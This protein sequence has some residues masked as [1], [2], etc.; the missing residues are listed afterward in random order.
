MI[1]ILPLLLLLCLPLAATGPAAAQSTASAVGGLGPRLDRAASDPAMRP[2]KTVI[3]ARDGRVLSERGFRGHSPSESTNI[4][5]A[6]KS[7]ISA[8]VGIAIDKGLLEGPDQKIAPILKA[9]LPVT[10]DPRINDIT[11]GNLL[12]MQAGLDRMSGANYGRW[13]SSRNW[14]R[15]ALSQPFVDQPGGEMLYSTASTHLLSAILTKVGR[16]PTLVL[17]REWLGPVEGFRIGA[18]ERDPQG[19]YLGGNQMAMSARSLLAFGELYRNGGKTAD[20]RQIVSADWISQSWQQRTNSR[21]SG[22]EYGYGWF[23]RQIGGEQVHFAWGY[24]GQMLYIVPSLDLTVVMTSEESGPSARNGY[25]DLLHGLL[26]DIIG[27]VRA[28]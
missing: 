20:G 27:A 7:I 4:K 25:R 26:A 28:A 10:P 12:S 24:G 2:L 11:I 18:W 3:V 13:V 23:T 6:S 14:V 8:L 17:A 21:F 5:S 16:R 9:D 19:I 15:F 22:D 1:R